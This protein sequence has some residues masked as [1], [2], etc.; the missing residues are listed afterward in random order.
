MSLQTTTTTTPGRA[1]VREVLPNLALGWY[2]TGKL[3]SITDV[4]GVL[5]H[6][7]SIH[8]PANHNPARPVSVINTGVTTILPRHDWFDN[9]CY[10]AVFSFNGSGELTG[11]HWI[12][13]TGLLNS[14]I[15]LTNSLSVGS[16]YNGIYQYAIREYANPETGLAEGFLL[17]VVGETYDGFLND[18]AAMA[19]TPEM[20]V[21]GIDNANGE[22]VKEGNTGGGTGML[23]MG[24]KAGTGSASRLVEA[25]VRG[26]K[27][28]FVVGCLVQSNFGKARNLMFRSV[29][30]GRL[31]QE[32]NDA[33][34]NE[35]ER[36]KDG[37]I[38]VV[39]ATDAPLH[40]TQLGRLVKRATVGV[41]RAGGWGSNSSGDVFIAFSTASKIPREPSL[42]TGMT[43]NEALFT[44]MVDQSVDVV[45]DTTINGLF[46]AAAEAVE[47]SILNALCMAETMEGPLGVRAEAI[48]L[49]RLKKVVEQYGGGK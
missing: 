24:F 18:V 2:P 41:A 17:P 20:V 28:Q 4:P 21:E 10:S 35:A 19:V 9:A 25:I 31:F 7:Q 23:T 38:I 15:V 39:L 26:E 12:N 3:N 33:E 8:R 46:E 14:P 1:R 5:V 49:E 32:D 13:E 16:A 43:R 22:R 30:V 42:P 29:P 44:A 36:K 47:E 6:T 27:K 37:S 11:S 40:P 48:D 34:L 45:Q